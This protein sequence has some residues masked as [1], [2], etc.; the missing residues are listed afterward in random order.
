MRHLYR[1]G[2]GFALCAA[3]SSMSGKSAPEELYRGAELHELCLLDGDEN[4]PED[5]L[6]ID[7]VHLDIR[8]SIDPKSRTVRGKV[9][10]QYLDKGADSIR[11]DAVGIEI[12][13][14]RQE[15]QAMDFRHKGGQLAFKN[16]CRGQS[17]TKSLWIE[18]QAR[19]R[20]GLY[21]RGWDRDF[22]FPELWSQGQGLEHRHWL[23]HQ[24]DQRDKLSWKLSVGFPRALNL[25]ERGFQFSSNGRRT[26][27]EQTDEETLWGFEQE[28]PQPSYLIALALGRFEDRGR[29]AEFSTQDLSLAAEPFAP[30]WGE[31]PSAHRLLAYLRWLETEI[32]SPYPWGPEF[33]E[34][35]VDNFKHGAMENTSSVIVG[36]SNLHSESRPHPVRTL[37]EIEVHELAHHWF[38]NSVTC[39]GGS[40]FWI[41]EGFATH[42]QWRSKTRFEGAWSEALA[43]R[44][45]RM[46]LERQSSKTPF[47]VRDEKAGTLA[48]YDR[49]AWVVGM[50][51]SHLG[52]SLFRSTLAE[53][54]DSNRY[55]VVDTKGFEEFLSQNS[56][57]DLKP[58]FEYWVE[59]R[60]LPEWTIRS[61]GQEWA[62]RRSE[63]GCE[64]IIDVWV[65]EPN[66]AWRRERLSIPA[67]SG[68][69]RIPWKYC[70]PDP[71]GRLLAKLKL[72]NW[73][74]SAWNRELTQ[75]DWSALAKWMGEEVLARSIERSGGAPGRDFD[76]WATSLSAAEQAPAVVLSLFLE[77]PDLREDM[78]RSVLKLGAGEWLPLRLAECPEWSEMEWTEALIAGAGDHH[79]AGIRSSALAAVHRGAGDPKRRSDRI[80]KGVERAL[81]SED[82]PERVE[83]AFIAALNREPEGLPVLLEAARADGDF[84]L[85]AEALRALKALE[86]WDISTATSSLQDVFDPNPRIASTARIYWSGIPES[87]RESA[88]DLARKS[89]ESWTAEQRKAFGE[90]SKL[91]L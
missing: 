60:S 80:S 22:E 14:L 85:R 84:A 57:V 69:I 18:F 50:L 28:L 6:S 5:G 30:D 11:L 53:W 25:I 16:A 35:V 77:R 42:F 48:F 83:A 59:G 89:T 51:E 3:G 66:S 54:L 47:S 1:L 64:Q 71:N 73:D 79:V 49:G 27:F 24:D 67:A 55:K 37:A 33:R 46:A 4:A 17:G 32:G 52:D 21:F 12:L 81:R 43:R 38:G 86:V 20:K 91:S 26:Q 88:M 78:A 75:G 76:R 45:S 87:A 41:H 23:P 58:F 15:G 40:D 44:N 74:W 34:V 63:P 19:P 2:L 29:W 61:E 13:T 70:I 10:I 90:F 68:L 8:L 31:A 9:T 82:A 7:Q 39:A 36:S 62:I 72:E 65:C 56:R